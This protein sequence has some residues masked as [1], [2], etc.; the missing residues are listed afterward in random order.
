LDQY[1]LSEN[2]TEISDLKIQA[3]DQHAKMNSANDMMTNMLYAVG[4]VWVSNMIHAYLTGPNP[5]A[6]NND[7]QNIQLVYDPVTHQPKIEFSIQLD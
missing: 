7:H 3:Q 1:N 6:N 2:P 5:T 4:T